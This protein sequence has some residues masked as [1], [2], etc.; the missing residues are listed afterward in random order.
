VINMKSHK[1]IISSIIGICLASSCSHV[2]LEKIPSNANPNLEIS[3]LEDDVKSAKLNQINMYSP[4]NYKRLVKHLNHAKENRDKNKDNESILEEVAKARTFLKKAQIIQSRGQPLLNEVIVARNSALEAKADR[5]FAKEMKD[6]DQKLSAAA[7]ALEEGDSKEA[8]KNRESLKNKYLD[9]ELR[10]IK[11]AALSP[12]FEIFEQAKKEGAEKEAPRTLAEAVR[13]MDQADSFIT[14]NRHDENGI[15]NQGEKAYQQAKRLLNF[16]RMA[17]TTDQQNSEELLLK[18]EAEAERANQL[19]IITHQS[20][21]LLASQQ[22]IKE[23]QAQFS[24]NEAEVFQDKDRLLIRLRGLNFHVGKDYILAESYPLLNKVQSVIQEI[25]PQRVIIEGHTDSVGSN[26]VNKRVSD[27][28]AQSVKKYFIAN[29]TLPSHQ[30]AA[31]GYGY[32]KP[33]TTNKT[34]KG[35]AVNRRVDVIL[36]LDSHQNV[37]S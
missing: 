9:L 31:I 7:E 37:G 11:H 25:Q 26:K 19:E 6:T 12:A 33:L 16:T 17:K 18:A 15:Q 22:K 28:R 32:T 24:P 20:A 23:I 34:S 36:E 3:K 27:R 4:M 30:I 2:E 10:S 8:E 1:L 35:R 14:V 21:S 5:Y 13:V 29:N